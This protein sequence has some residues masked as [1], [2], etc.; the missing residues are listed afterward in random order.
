MLRQPFIDRGDVDGGLVAD[1]EFVVSGGQ[2]AVAFEPVDAAFD[3]VAL[4]V[5]VGSKVGGRPPLDPF[6]RRLAA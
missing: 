5:E 2:G 3:G 1:G 4:L 6:L